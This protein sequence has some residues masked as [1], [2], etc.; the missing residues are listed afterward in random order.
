[1]P[2]FSRS[3]RVSSN[4]TS[5]YIPHCLLH[6]PHPTLPYPVSPYLL[7]PSVPGP[8][9]VLVPVPPSST[10]PY[11]ILSR[12]PPPRVIPHFCFSQKLTEK[13][14]LPGAPHPTSIQGGLDDRRTVG[15]RPGAGRG[16]Q[17]SLSRQMVDAVQVQSLFQQQLS[18]STMQIRAGN[19]QVHS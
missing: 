15:E 10:R 12:S 5:R 7:F 8:V 1:M 14:Q 2:D 17:S 4:K 11:L 3:I 18:G 13:K 9:L 16:S 6:K 19:C